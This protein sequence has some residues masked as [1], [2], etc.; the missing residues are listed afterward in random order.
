[1]NVL[2]GQLRAGGANA[3]LQA[4]KKPILHIEHEGAL[5]DICAR[6]PKSSMFTVLAP[7][8]LHGPLSVC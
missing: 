1:M 6:S 7:P 4:L 5:A 2:V 3:P 8:D